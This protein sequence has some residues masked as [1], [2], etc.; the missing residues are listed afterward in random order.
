MNALILFITLL[1]YLVIGFAA[2]A[3]AALLIHGIGVVTYKVIRIL[4]AMLN[5]AIKEPEEK[6]V[7]KVRKLNKKPK[8]WKAAHV[9]PPKPW[10]RK[11]KGKK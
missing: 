8:G 11:V 3:L 9:E 7:A 6:L 10:P 5:A 1:I 4:V 2:L